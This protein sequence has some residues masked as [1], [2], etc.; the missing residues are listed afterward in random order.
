MA[1][2]DPTVNFGF[3]LPDVG[4]DSGLWG[5]LLNAILGDD[6]AGIDKLLFDTITVANAALPVAGSDSPTPDAASMTGEIDILTERYASVS[7]SGSGM[8]TMDLDVANA[9]YTTVTGEITF[10]FSNVPAGDDFVFIQI[11]ITNGAAQIVNWPAEVDWPDGT[12]PSL[13]ANV[14]LVTGYTRDGGTIWHLALA[15][16]NSG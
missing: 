16:R 9:F 14:D 2:Q 12:E 15:M 6:V 4:G 7:L 11:E 13:S 5:V 8:V 3:N 1:T 10:A